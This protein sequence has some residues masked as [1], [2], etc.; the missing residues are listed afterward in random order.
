MTA[1][2]QLEK[3]SAHQTIPLC[4]LEPSQTNPRKRFDETRLAELAES[5]K[6]QGVLQP[7]LVRE[8]HWPASAPDIGSPAGESVTA[9]GRFEIIAG[10]RRYRAARLAELTEVPCFVRNLTDRQVLHA[11][12]IENLQR[13]DLHPL[14]EAEGYEKMMKEHGSTAEGLAAEIGKSKAYIY[15]RLKLCALAAEARQAFYDGL[16]DASTALLIARIPVAK[17]QI[18]AM[19]VI[20][21]RDCKGDV[22][23][24]RPAR[25]HIQNEFMTDL[26]KAPFPVKSAEL[27]AGIGACTD[28]DKRTGNQPEIF[29]DVKSKDVCTDTACFAMKK[30]AHI[31]TQKKDAE[32]KGYAVI[33]GKAAVKILPNAR[34]HTYLESGS[35][36]VKLADAC[37]HDPK[38]RSWEEVLGKASFKPAKG[39]DKPPVQKT[40]VENTHSGALLPV[41]KVEEATRALR[42][43]GIEVN[44][45]RPAHGPQSEENAK[46]G[47]ANLFRQRLFDVLHQRVDAIAS[48]D[49]AIISNW[50]Y[51]ILAE[52]SFESSASDDRGHVARRYMPDSE[53]KDPQK[54]AA[55]FERDIPELTTRQHILI[56]FDLMTIGE[57]RVCQWDYARPPQNMISIAKEVGIDVAAIERGVADEVRAAIEAKAKKQASPKEPAAPAAKKVAAKKAASSTTK[58]EGASA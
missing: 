47:Q 58:T 41:V 51:R 45:A 18:Q 3:L 35:G 56:L 39:A 21:Q 24:F 2:V 20:T 49:I 25:D 30:T 38:R 4:M 42:D 34:W 16:L 50:L 6:G 33:T 48:G 40:L 22:M 29:G 5:I 27:L 57:T 10:E 53:I 19:R 13:D 11:Q 37:P 7:L 46:I 26:E 52:H 23:S 14:E 31:L 44:P 9:S 54:L 15:A 1:S 32:A 36:Y 28:C 8:I 43:M 55:E 12:V 17:L